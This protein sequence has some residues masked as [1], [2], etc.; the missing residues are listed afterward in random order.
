MKK[1]LSIL[2]VL[3][4]MSSICFAAQFSDFDL[5]NQW[6]SEGYEDI[7][8]FLVEKEVIKGYPDGTFKPENTITRAEMSKVLVVAFDVELK[9]EEAKILFPDVSE[10]A[11]YAKYV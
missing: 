2:F 4:V 11:W 3:V 8:N 10:N 7:M 6:L 1:F 9:N 5:K